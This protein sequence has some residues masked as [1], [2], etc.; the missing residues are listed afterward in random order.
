MPCGPAMPLATTVVAKAA[1]IEPESTSSA[2]TCA[3]R[4]VEE[5]RRN[6][7]T[8]GRTIE[9][10]GME[11]LKEW[12]DAHPGE[13]E[14]P[15][16]FVTA[17]D[18]SPEDHVKVQAAIQRWVDSSISKTCN[19]PNNYTMEQVSDLY[20]YMYDLG[21]K[22]VTVFRYGSRSQVLYLGNG[23]TLPGCKYCG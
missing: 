11:S 19:V 3:A 18:L 8:D 10:D 22:G 4:R 16:Y 5:G 2:P 1:W 17:M 6:A 12:F 20:K 7:A 13:T 9:S 23:E 14:L 21:C 15:D